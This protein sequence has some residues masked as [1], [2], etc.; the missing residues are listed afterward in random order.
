MRTIPEPAPP[1]ASRAD[2][3][4]NV[5][6]I[7][8]AAA[9]VFAEHGVDAPVREVAARAGVGVGTLYRHFPDRVALVVA[10]FR[11]AVDACA[12]AAPDLAATL[13]PAEAVTAW[14]HRFEQF[15]ATKQGL[16]AVLHSGDPALAP[17]PDYFRD[18]L[19]PALEGL[20]E[21]A[22]TAGELRPDVGAEELLDATRALAGRPAMIDLLVE[23]L[24]PRT[25]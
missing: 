17:L 13:A 3:R 10:V 11:D 8:H 24:R 4:R 1:R 18:R 2:A 25:R 6:R 23:G 19:L 16:G 7:R 9:E 20:L 15:V 14:L 21:A 5:E 12:D 22:V